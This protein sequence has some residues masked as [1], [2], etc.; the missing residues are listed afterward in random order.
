MRLLITSDFHFGLSRKAH[1]TAESSSRREEVSRDLL[2]QIL[3]TPHDQ[4]ICVGDFFDRFSNP[5]TVILQTVPLAR[6]FSRILAGNHD[7]SNREGT[8]GSL[9]VLAEILRDTPTHVVMGEPAWMGSAA[10]VPHQLTQEAFEAAID[11]VC[12]QAADK[13]GWR[14]LFLHCNVLSPFDGSLSSLN[15]TEDLAHQALSAFHHIV[16]GHEHNP[17]QLFDDRLWVVGSHFT[18]AF[19]QLG[20]HR[21]LVFDTETGQMESITHWRADEHVYTGQDTDAPPGRQFY[22]LTE[23]RDSR[24]PMRLFKEGALGVRVAPPERREAVTTLTRTQF[25][26]LND[27]ISDLL[28]DEPELLN[29]WRQMAC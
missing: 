17:R 15:L 21:H 8:E 29:L 20:D 22:D 7:V 2:K 11:R 27:E 18:V 9:T 13:P 1:F 6:R 14:L 24:S 23:C 4:A 16:V 25:R 5:E 12:Q 19:D 26:T 28:K 10:F 3:E